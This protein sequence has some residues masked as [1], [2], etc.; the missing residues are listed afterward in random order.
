MT[1]ERCFNCGVLVEFDYYCEGYYI[2]LDYYC[3]DCFESLQ[4]AE[5]EMSWY[6][7]NYPMQMS[8]GEE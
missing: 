4:E 5:F 6:E 7:D 3:A 1:I 2:E 8:R